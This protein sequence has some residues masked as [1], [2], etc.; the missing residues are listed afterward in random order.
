MALLP[1][2]LWDLRIARMWQLKFC[3]MEIDVLFGGSYW[4]FRRMCYLRL[5][6]H[7]DSSN[8]IFLTNSKYKLTLGM[9]LCIN[10]GNAVFTST[11][12]AWNFH[13]THYTLELCIILAMECQIWNHMPYGLFPSPHV[14]KCNRKS[15]KHSVS[16]ARTVPFHRLKMWTKSTKLW[17]VCKTTLHL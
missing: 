16:G 7:E 13:L 1:L 10:I 4:Y 9:Y 15:I 14:K 3:L 2:E 5:N 12:K 17:P 8:S 6:V 11:G